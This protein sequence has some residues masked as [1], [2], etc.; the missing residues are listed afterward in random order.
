M[1]LEVVHSIANRVPSAHEMEL[2]RRMTKIGLVASA[3]LHESRVVSEDE[4][5]HV[6]RDALTVIEKLSTAKDE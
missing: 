1:A 6:R 2:E 5:S 4:A 3:A